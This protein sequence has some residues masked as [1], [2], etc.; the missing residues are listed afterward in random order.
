MYNPKFVVETYK[1]E[2]VF[3][4]ERDNQ[5]PTRRPDLVANYKN[6]S[7]SEFCCSSGQEY[8]N[9]KKTREE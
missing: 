2:C 5:I 7:S 9:K 6:L 3:E 8:K 4:I 1:V